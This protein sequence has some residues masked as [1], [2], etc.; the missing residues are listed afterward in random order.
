MFTNTKLVCASSAAAEKQR[1]CA[2]NHLNQEHEL[3][4]SGRVVPTG[5]MGPVGVSTPPIARPRA[6][7]VS[8][9]S[10]QTRDSRPGTIFVCQTPTETGAASACGTRCVRPSVPRRAV[11]VASLECVWRCSVAAFLR[12][13]VVRRFTC[14]AGVG[15]KTRQVRMKINVVEMR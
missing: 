6:R 11:R 13:L 4:L 7:A 3:S 2:G 10:L 14:A 12:T 9:G 15:S 5:S 8:C 1:A